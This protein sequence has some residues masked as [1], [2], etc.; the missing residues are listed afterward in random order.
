[1]SKNLSNVRQ[2]CSVA[3]VP[4]MMPRLLNVSNAFATDELSTYILK[5]LVCNIV[6]TKIL[7]NYVSYTSEVWELNELIH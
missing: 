7:P 5:G 4:C 3:S 2:N 6:M 1:M